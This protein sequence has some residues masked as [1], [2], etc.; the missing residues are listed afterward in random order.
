[1]KRTQG[2]LF[3]VAMFQILQLGLTFSSKLAGEVTDVA[4]KAVKK[5][6][7]KASKVDSK[8]ATKTTTAAKGDANSQLMSIL[9]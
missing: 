4:A 9:E 5:V 7:S 1:M 3:I 8:A 2:W 6:A